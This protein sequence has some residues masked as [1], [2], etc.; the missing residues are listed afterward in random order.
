MESPTFLREHRGGRARASD[1]VL[2]LSHLRWGFVYQRPNH[3]MSRYA[4]NHRVFFVEEPIFDADVPRLEV[5]EI[6]PSLWTAVPH[7]PAGRSPRA[8]EVMLA[9]LLDGLVVRDRVRAPLLWLYTPM[10]VPFTRHLEHA[11]IVYDCMD[12]LSLF[13]GAPRELVD[14][15]RELFAMAD[16][17]FTG[18]HG[19]WEAKKERHANIHAVPSSVDAAH[20]ARARTKLQDPSDQRS[21]AHPRLGFFG[22]LDERFD[23]PL[24]EQS[25]RARP[26]WQFVLVGPVVKIDPATLPRLPNIHYLGPKSYAEL[27]AYLAGWDVAIMP[28]ARNESTRYI[29]PTKTLEY[30][31]AG[32]P[33]VSTSIRD[34]VRT[35]ADKALVRIADRADDFVIA[36]E[37]A[38]AE[39]GTPRGDARQMA[40]DELLSQTSW[41]R[42]WARMHALVERA[43]TRSQARREELSCSTT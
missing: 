10:A 37:E 2:C 24:L 1:D 35:F 28:F 3:L 30:L 32:K 39:R 34:V 13:R 36:A 43:I 14:R 40:V 23:V 11:G 5:V 26:Q 20:F 38:L 6:E 22:V 19:L 18:G 16:I 7:L 17:V 21:I 27:P 31:A 9:E 29:S 8:V 41:D 12:E 42:T 33:V 4:R 25:A 15:E